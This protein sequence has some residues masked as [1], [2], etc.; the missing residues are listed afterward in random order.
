[1]KNG[2]GKKRRFD[3]RAPLNKLK[4]DHGLQTPLRDR[5]PCIYLEREP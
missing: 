2:K 3:W 1:M 4:F 5:K